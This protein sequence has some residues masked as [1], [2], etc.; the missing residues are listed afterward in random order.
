MPPNILYTIQVWIISRL[1]L[2]C[3]II[4]I[5]TFIR[6]VCLCR[7]AFSCMNM[8]GFSLASRAK[9]RE[10]VS[11]ILPL[12]I[13]TDLKWIQFPLHFWTY[14]NSH[15]YSQM[16]LWRLNN[17]FLS[18]IKSCKEYFQPSKLSKFY[19]LFSTV[20]AAIRQVQP[21]IKQTFACSPSYG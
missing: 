19:L 7:K 12:G 3:N 11:S 1:I 14:C 2:Y 15:H 16:T 21:Q 10:C 17:V 6:T 4:L 18:L 8:K 20:P 13:Q 5:K 9:D